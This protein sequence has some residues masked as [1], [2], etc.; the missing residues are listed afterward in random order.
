M[1]LVRM[2]VSTT[3]ITHTTDGV[4]GEQDT[5]CWGSMEYWALEYSFSEIPF[6]V[7]IDWKPTFNFYGYSG[8][9]VMV[10]HFRYAIF[11]KLRTTQLR[12]QFN[13]VS[14]NLNNIFWLK[15]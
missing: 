15:I 2:L 1:D 9:G 12:Y 4:K 11:S 8:F 14:W 13:H 5:M 6:N 10:V 7:S 3:E